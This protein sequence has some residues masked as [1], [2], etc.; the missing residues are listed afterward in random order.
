M[1]KNNKKAFSLPEMLMAMLIIAIASF[2][3][4]PVLTKP[5]PQIDTVGVRGQF[6]CYYDDNG[7]LKQEEYQERIQKEI[8]NAGNA[9]EFEFNQR[10]K[11]YLIIALGAASNNAPGQLR[12]KYVPYIGES[13]LDKLTIN[14]AKA[15]PISIEDKTTIVR[16]SN[17]TAE[18]VAGSGYAVNN[19]NGLAGGNIK[20]CRLLTAGKPCGGNYAG[21]T[22]VACTPA[23]SYSKDDYIIKVTCKDNSN[24]LNEDVIDIKDLTPTP[25]SI[26]PL[27]Y[28]NYKLNVELY[29]SMY[30]SKTYHQGRTGNE[31]SAIEQ[32]LYSIHP[33]RKS[34]L[35]NNFINKKYGDNGSNNKNGAVLILW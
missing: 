1:V 29:D 33:Q 16:S 25:N 27:T 4:L 26:S 18:V 35:I 23:Y 19:K 5:K 20:S 22:Q 10:P 6:A 3:M 2:A 14:V 9:C 21:L 15:N 31:K 30:T 17:G 13:S 7:V 11:N 8:K 12:T 32:I 24:N 34:N 28:G